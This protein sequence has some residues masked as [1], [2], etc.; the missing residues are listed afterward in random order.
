MIF[1]DAFRKLIFIVT[2]AMKI[3]VSVINFHTDSFRAFKVYV[4]MRILQLYV[5]LRGIPTKYT[6]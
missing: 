5:L 1:L 3:T 2:A 6:R 4:S